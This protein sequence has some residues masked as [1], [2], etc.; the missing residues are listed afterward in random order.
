[1]KTQHE[2]IVAIMARART[3]KVW[4]LPQDFMNPDL[5][6]LFVGYEASA[7]LSELG[8]QYPEMIESVREGKYIKRAVRW[9][10]IN[11]W[12]DTIPD[13]LKKIFKEYG[14]STQG[15]LL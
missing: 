14:V 11:N 4:F 2:K 12:W 10:N 6:D 9:N 8:S 3:D 13:S 7:R 15:K 1:M 5:G